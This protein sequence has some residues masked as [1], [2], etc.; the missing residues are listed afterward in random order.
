MHKHFIKGSLR[1]RRRV[2][3]TSSTYVR[4]EEN[5]GNWRPRGDSLIFDHQWELEKLTRLQ[6]VERMRLFLR[7]R[8]RLKSVN[9]LGKSSSDE[10]ATNGIKT[11]VS[12]TEPKW[13]IPNQ[14]TLND[15]EAGIVKKILKFVRL[16]IPTNK[17]PPT[18]NKSGA[19]TDTAYETDTSTF[20]NSTSASSVSFSSGKYT[21]SDESS[22]SFS[23]HNDLVSKVK[24]RSSSDLKHLLSPE[25]IDKLKKSLSFNKLSTVGFYIAEVFEKRVGVV[26]SKKGYMNF[27]EEKAR[28]WRKRWVVVRRPYIL[29]FN[30]EKDP[31]IRGLINLAYARVE[32]SEDQ[33]AMLKT[34]TSE[35]MQDWLYAINPLLAG[36][37]KS[38]HGKQSDS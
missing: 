17:E 30:D 24:S 20:G 2:L 33:Q 37:M 10:E 35:E 13:P 31:V 1:R 22:F 9:L 19:A 25:E 27:L 32:Y 16:H 21:F 26:V 4:G 3:D 12:P 36:Q 34:L 15:K 5:L 8:Q 18:G 38:K 11:P 6:N 7:L 29:L 23:S 28:G 14:V